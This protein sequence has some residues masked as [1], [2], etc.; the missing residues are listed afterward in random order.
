MDGGRERGR[1]EKVRWGREREERE[2]AMGE[3]EG[4]IDCNPCIFSRTAV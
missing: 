4:D 2:G 1:I 3:R